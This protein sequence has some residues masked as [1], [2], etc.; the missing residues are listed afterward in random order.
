MSPAGRGPAGA[1]AYSWAVPARHTRLEDFRVGVVLDHEHAP[2]SSEVTALLSERRGRTRPGRR[3]SRRRLARGCGP[4]ADYES[5]GFHVQL[6]FAFQSPVRSSRRSRGH[7][8]GEPTRSRP[9]PPGPATST[10]STFSCARQTSRQRS[11][12]TPTLRRAHDHDSRRGAA[13][14]RPGFWISHASLR[15]CPPWS[16]PSAYTG[17][18]P[19][20]VQIVGPALRGRHGDHVRRIARRC[21]RR[22]LNPRPSSAVLLDQLAKASRESRRTST[23][24]ARPPRPTPTSRRGLRPPHRRAQAGGVSHRGGHRLQ[25]GGDHAALASQGPAHSDLRITCRSTPPHK[26]HARPRDSRPRRCVCVVCKVK[27]GPSEI[28]PSK[29]ASDGPPSYPT[30]SPPGRGYDHFVLPI[31]DTY[32]HLNPKG[33]HYE[34][35][36]VLSDSRS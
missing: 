28:F 36:K 24:N 11:R 5:F 33:C 6:F 14:Q 13:L 2:V 21:D 16:H 19:V 22:A 3:D 26:R 1:K 25:T 17:G 30:V 34:T 18:L 20:G 23:P 32:Y 27:R 9:V 8:A 4:C 10:T 29:G 15:A 12:T 31:D 35:L 7:R